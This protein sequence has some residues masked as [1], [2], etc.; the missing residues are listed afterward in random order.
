MR[1]ICFSLFLL[2]ALA[3]AQQPPEQACCRD[4]QSYTP[5]APSDASLGMVVQV[6]VHVMQPADGKGNF[7]D[8]PAQRH[9]IHTLVQNAGQRYKS[10]KPMRLPT[11]SPYIADGRVDL[12]VGADNIYFHPVADW[13]MANLDLG[14]RITKVEKWYRTYVEK[15][16]DLPKRDQAIHL[17]LA[18]NDSSQAPRLNHGV[19]SGLGTQGWVLVL[20]MYHETQDKKLWP[21][22]LVAHELGHILGLN[23]T[24]FPT[25]PINDG[26]DDTPTYPVN[27]NC[28]NGP[29]CSNNIMDYNA[30]CNALTACQLAHIHHYLHG[31]KGTLYK[32]VI[33][34]WCETHQWRDIVLPADT[35]VDWRGRRNLHGHLTLMPGASLR[36]HCR[37][38]LPPGATIR[39]MPG[40]TLTVDGGH[41]TCLCPEGKWQGV[42]LYHK[43]KKKG[44]LLLENGG[45]LL[46]TSQPEPV[47]KKWKKH[48][49]I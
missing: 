13:S 18:E 7:Q 20:D 4:W 40:A 24:A 10:L 14:K 26:C 16:P 46:N 9:T 34:T 22:H 30:D 21:D 23:H 8:T 35:V 15:N 28:W 42:I 41:L 3:T 27:T 49:K 33:P 2:L 31:L 37:T 45:Q 19:A 36:L 43:G 6:V 44:Q 29:Q 47:H 5:G 1:S 17:F 48:E 12:W 32:A 25:A 11:T 39:V 38:H